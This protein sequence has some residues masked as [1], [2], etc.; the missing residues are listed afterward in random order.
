M[1]ISQQ[2]SMKFEKFQKALNQNEINLINNIKISMKKFIYKSRKQKVTFA[3]NNNDDNDKLNI[4]F[5][6]ER[7]NILKNILPNIELQ[8]NH[9]ININELSPFSD[10]NKE[11]N[12]IKI[13]ITKC[14]T[15]EFIAVGRH[16]NQ[17]Y[18]TIDKKKS[19]LKKYPPN[20][21]A[22]YHQEI[23]KNLTNIIK[24]S[25]NLANNCSL[26]QMSLF[27]KFIIR[28]NDKFDECIKKITDK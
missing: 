23:L 9:V 25:N 16:I 17:A 8:N 13:N 18:N 6:H 4:C 3:Q 14:F 2:V 11:F 5:K 26:I 7:F 27:E 21:M 10:V 12:S 19:V 28:I 20:D 24:L 1:I 22:N 15:N